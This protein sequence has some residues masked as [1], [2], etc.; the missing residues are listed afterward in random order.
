M[1]AGLDFLSTSNRKIYDLRKFD[2]SGFV[3][4]G[5][6]NYHTAG[7]IL[8]NHQ[9]EHMIE[10]CYLVKGRQFYEVVNHP[11]LLKGGDVLITKPNLS[12]GT[13][14]YPESVGELYWLICDIRKRRDLLFCLERRLSK[15]LINQLLNL[16]NIH[17]TGNGKIKAGFERIELLSQQK[18]DPFNSL[19]LL[20]GIISLLVEIIELSKTS[21]VV[22]LP[23]DIE[24]V[25]E[26]IS[27]NY[28]E[29]I[30]I[31]SLCDISQLSDSRFKHKFRQYI[32]RS[33]ID[34]IN[35]LKVEK[36]KLL[37]QEKDIK[38]KNVGYLLGF[39]SPAYFTQVF[40][41]YTRITPKD[42][43]GQFYASQ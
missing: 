37:L 5:H 8:V 25:I 23:E 2:V 11:F 16:K 36:A 40:R 7:K 4:L 3:L 17:F 18:V 39:S 30:T 27:L 34:Y 13:K 38:I 33:P 26:F 43:R 1:K 31:A 10:I 19:L 22:P 9:H 14:N 20:N 35:N 21:D 41:K 42:Y 6:Y 24:K 12:H 15:S 28:H 29:N 32:G